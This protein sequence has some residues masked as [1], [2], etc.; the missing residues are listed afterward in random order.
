MS[1]FVSEMQKKKLIVTKSVSEIKHVEKYPDFEKLVYVP[2]LAFS[3]EY[4]RW[5]NRDK[6]C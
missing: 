3:N 1:Y 4:W 2:I 6:L 5:V